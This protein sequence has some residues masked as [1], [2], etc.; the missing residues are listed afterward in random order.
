MFEQGATLFK[1]ARENFSYSVRL[2]IGPK[3]M[4]L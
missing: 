1:Y 3:Q 2:S 4:R